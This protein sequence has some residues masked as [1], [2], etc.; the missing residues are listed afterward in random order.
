MIGNITMVICSTKIIILP[1]IT[2]HFV[3]ILHILESTVEI[4][5]TIDENMAIYTVIQVGSKEELYFRKA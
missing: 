2:K 1:E 4:V 5:I 3:C